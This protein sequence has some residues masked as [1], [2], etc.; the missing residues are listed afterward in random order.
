MRKGS[1]D[2]ASGHIRQHVAVNITAASG[3]K[4]LGRFRERSACRCLVDLRLNVMNEQIAVIV[5]LNSFKHPAQHKVGEDFIR[6]NRMRELIRQRTKHLLDS[7]LRRLAHEAER[8]AAEVVVASGEPLLVCLERRVPGCG[9]RIAQREARLEHPEPVVQR[10]G[11]VH[12]LDL[13]ADFLVV[14]LRPVEPNT[15]VQ[16]RD[17]Q[18]AD[19]VEQAHE[20]D[21]GGDLPYCLRVG[22]EGAGVRRPGLVNGI[23]AAV[24]FVDFLAEN[25]CL[26]GVG[27]GA[28]DATVVDHAG[29]AADGEGAPA[30]TEEPYLMFVCVVLDYELIH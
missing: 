21:R 16:A 11:V 5:Q 4:G 30:E 3:A 22:L 12:L 26:G 10:D 14:E 7:V 6:V 2:I 28:D 8:L 29:D 1:P 25:A 13:A 20:F 24:D 27:A 18:A 17:S 9:F 15:G 19:G 23:G